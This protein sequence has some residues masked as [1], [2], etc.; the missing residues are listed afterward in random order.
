MEARR[1]GAAA[2]WRRG[3]LEQRQRGGAAY[4]SVDVLGQSRG[5]A[6]A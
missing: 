6:E 5:D 3:I 1:I 4:L 2:T